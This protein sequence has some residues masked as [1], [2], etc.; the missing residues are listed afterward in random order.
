MTNN[1]DYPFQKI[2]VIDDSE[3]DR[4]ILSRLANKYCFSKEVLDFNMA[5]K[6]LTYFEEN[7]NNN[8]MLPEII[9][10]DINMP[11]MNGFEFLEQ[12]E[13]FPESIKK[14]VSIIVLTS[15]NNPADSERALKN[16]LVCA[17]HNKPLNQ[18]K[19]HQVIAQ[20]R[21]TPVKVT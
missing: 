16:P 18:D 5:R 11:E 2:A 3:M 8:I 10:L 15:S 17:Y 12:F 13:A 21:K 6:G 1:L 9:F 20:V 14:Q 7:L 4:Y 19:L